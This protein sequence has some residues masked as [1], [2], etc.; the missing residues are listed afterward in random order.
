MIRA[1]VF[2]GAS[3]AVGV[4]LGLFQDTT[5]N[6]LNAVAGTT[7]AVNSSETLEI[8]H[9]MTAGTTSST[10]FK[11]RLGPASAGTVVLNGSGAARLFGGVATSSLVI[12]EYA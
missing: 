5:S 10:T 2:A 12:E 7:P 4:G 9:V 6:A 8:V 11:L 1:Q 3:I